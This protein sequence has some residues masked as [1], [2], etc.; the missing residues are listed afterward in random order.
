M[1][2]MVSTTTTTH[3]QAHH[4]SSTMVMVIITIVP[5]TNS[6]TTTH[7]HAHHGSPLTRIRTHHHLHPPL[8]IVR[9]LGAPLL[10]QACNSPCHR[11]Q[12]LWPKRISLDGHQPT[13]PT[14]RAACSYVSK[15]TGTRFLQ[16]IGRTGA[17]LQHHLLEHQLEKSRRGG[18]LQSRQPPQ[19]H[20]HLLRLE[21]LRGARVVPRWSSPRRH[22]SLAW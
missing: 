5:T 7:H 10:L 8:E 19:A 16:V 20:R 21:A 1:V 4:G 11:C 22:L 18:S 14:V 12:L 6:T 3:R 2:T 13:R 15:G 17:C 9:H